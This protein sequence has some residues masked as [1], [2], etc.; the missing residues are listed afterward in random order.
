MQTYPYK[1]TVLC[2]F[3]LKENL[4]EHFPNNADEDIKVKNWL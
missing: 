3:K 2:Y 4:C 1:D